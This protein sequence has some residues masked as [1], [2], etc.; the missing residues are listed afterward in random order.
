MIEAT[1]G[2]SSTGERR[3]EWGFVQIQWIDILEQRQVLLTQQEKDKIEAIRIGNMTAIN[4]IL[5]QYI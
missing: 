5:S 3:L 4:I 2:L 1:I